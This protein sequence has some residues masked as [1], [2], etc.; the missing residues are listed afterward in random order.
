MSKIGRIKMFKGRFELY[1]AR[2]IKKYFPIKVEQLKG[3]KP[4]MVELYEE[5]M[6]VTEDMFQI[7]GGDTFKINKK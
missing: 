5:G 2:N 4:V 1:N 7:S 6:W 3:Q